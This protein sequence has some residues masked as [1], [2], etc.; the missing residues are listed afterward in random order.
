MV[1]LSAAA[2]F[3]G[4]L[5]AGLCR[6]SVFRD[7]NREPTGMYS[8]RVGTA[9]HPRTALHGLLAGAYQRRGLHGHAS[10][11]ALKSAEQK[12]PLPRVRDRGFIGS[13]YKS[14]RRNHRALVLLFDE[15]LHLVALQSVNQLADGFGVLVVGAGD[16]DVGV[17]G[18]LTFDGQGVGGGVQAGFQSVVGVDQSQIHLIQY[19]G[20]GGRFQ[21]ADT[22]IV[23]VVC[24]IPRCGQDIGVVLQGDHTGLGQQQQGAAAVGG[25]IGDG[26][27]GTLGDIV[28][29]VQLAGVDAK[30][31]DVD[32]GYADQVGA[33]A[34]VELIQV[35]LVLEEVG[36]QTTF[37]DLQVR[38][39]VVG[40]D[41]DIQ[42][43][44]LFGQS[45]FDELEDLRVGNSSGGD[46]EFLSSVG[47]K[48]S[49]QRQDS[50]DLFHEMLRKV[51]SVPVIYLRE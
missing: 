41:L 11:V 45:G 35:G 14:E 13:D 3:I 15:G 19:A 39:H 40:E 9:L 20:Q 6:P 29:R 28:Q 38:L 4:G 26:H 34:L 37:G 5:G 16:Q 46:A 18:I 23:R 47:A 31:L 8:R 51:R 7:E 27:G 36:I 17:R 22:D 10:M 33:A 49:G 1:L 50:Y 25:V 44:A 12:N 2:E 42:L 48:R 24:D 30:R 43:H 32:V 21:F